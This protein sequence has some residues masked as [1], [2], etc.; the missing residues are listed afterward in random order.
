M[1]WKHGSA[2]GETQVEDKRLNPDLN[3]DP[4]P[5]PNPRTLTESNLTLNPTR[6]Q[7]E[8]STYTPSWFY[9]RKAAYTQGA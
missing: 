8:E 9:S 1:I 3:P 6:A 7:I 4:D 5:N 2:S